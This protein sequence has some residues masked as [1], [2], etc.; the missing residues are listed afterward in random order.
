[1]LRACIFAVIAGGILAFA[2][3]GCSS[4]LETGYE[5]VKL[6]NMT[7]TERRGLY[8]EEFSPEAREAQEEEAKDKQTGFLSPSPGGP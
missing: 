5:P 8:A 1:M 4:R 2:A 3:M 6:G 7:P